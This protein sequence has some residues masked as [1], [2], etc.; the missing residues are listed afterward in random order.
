LAV[1]ATRAR[2]D[3]LQVRFLAARGSDGVTVAVRPAHTR[4]DGDVVFACAAPD[5]SGRTPN[6][7]VL[8]HL[9]TEAVAAAVRNAVA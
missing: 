4:Y 6:L 3:K 5:D 1:V 9:S 8:G 2:L 7:D